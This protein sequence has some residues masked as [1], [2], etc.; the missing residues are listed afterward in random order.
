MDYRKYRIQ[1]PKNL[2]VPKP[3]YS[4]SPRLQILR[5]GAVL[6]NLRG[7]LSAIQLHD[8]ATFMADKINYVLANGVLPSEIESSQPSM[9]QTV[10]YQFLSIC[11]ISSQ[12]PGFVLQVF[13]SPQPS[14]SGRGRKLSP[15]IHTRRRVALPSFQESDFVSTTSRCSG[16]EAS[17]VAIFRA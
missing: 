4:E 10:P 1:L 5:T 3:H 17:S 6:L 15:F 8:E 11:L 16:A 2:M 13:P 7:M 9:S 12:I 14:P